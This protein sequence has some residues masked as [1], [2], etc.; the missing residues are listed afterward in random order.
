MTL[1]LIMATSTQTISDILSRSDW[2]QDNILRIMIAFRHI[3]E[4]KKLESKYPFLNLYCDWVLHPEISRSTTGFKILEFLTDAMI[5]HNSNPKKSKWIND[6]INEIISLHKFKENIETLCQELNINR[7][8]LINKENWKKF[9]QLL[10]IYELQ[11][12]PI[13]FSDNLKGK[14]RYIYDSIQSKASKSGY[15]GNAILG[16]SFTTH[17]GNIYW[18]IDTEESIKNGLTIVGQIVIIDQ[19]MIDNYKLPGV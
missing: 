14:A 6:A 12:K 8:V 19:K 10:I 1:E 7:D 3:L 17:Q 16:I 2:T 18:K 15:K 13:K 9:V 11:K 4:E 5:A